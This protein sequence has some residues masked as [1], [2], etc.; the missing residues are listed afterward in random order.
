MQDNIRADTY[1]SE[2]KGRLNPSNFSGDDRPQC[3]E[4]TREQTLQSIYDWI[5]ARGYP[6]V[7]LLIGA[8]GAGKSTVATTVAGKYQRRGQLGCHMFFLRGRS[9][10]GSV[11]Q[12]IAYSL[13]FYNQSI[14]ESLVE[15]LRN[16]GDIGPSDLKAKFKILLQDSLS[17]ITTN[18]SSPVLIVLDALDDL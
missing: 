7:F 2:L 10:P 9:Q 6:N 14:A 4:D 13:A 18:M 11:L 1:L 16:S 5:D 17:A 15:Q 12:T 3:L 8:A